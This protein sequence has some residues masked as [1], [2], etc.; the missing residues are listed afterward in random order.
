VKSAAGAVC[1]ESVRFHVEWQVT[2]RDLSDVSMDELRAVVA[3]KH[4]AAAPAN[5]T[6]SPRAQ[7]DSLITTREPRRNTKSI[8]SRDAIGCEGMVLVAPEGI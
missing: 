5:N 8:I 3:I 7:H 2:R 1:S 4:A 6:K